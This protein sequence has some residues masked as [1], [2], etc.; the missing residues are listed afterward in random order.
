MNLMSGVSGG[1]GLVLHTGTGLFWTWVQYTM[2]KFIK[3]SLLPESLTCYFGKMFV[4]IKLRIL[5]HC[6]D[7]K[8]GVVSRP[9]KL[10]EHV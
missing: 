6:S 1:A 5:A 7:L 8:M 2:S 10:G 3:S 4:L 9:L